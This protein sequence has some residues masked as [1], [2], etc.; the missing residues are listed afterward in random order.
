MAKDLLTL[1]STVCKEIGLPVPA[2]AASSNE[3][4]TMQLV[5]YANACGLELMEA[6]E[7]PWLRKLATIN[8]VATQSVYS[9]A[10]SA[11]PLAAGTYT[12]NRL[13]KDTEFD[14]TNHWRFLGSI[15]DSEWNSWVYGVQ[16]TPI[17][18]IFRT[19]AEDQIEVWPV[20][21]ASSG[22][23][24]LNFIAN[25]WV[26]GSGSP[27]PVQ[28]AFVADT[29]VHLFDQRLFEVGV[30]W[31]WKAG[32]GLEFAEDRD[33]YDKRLDLRKAH[34]RTARR[35]SLTGGRHAPHFLDYQNVPETGYGS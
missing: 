19:V 21:S 35:L 24:V 27:R 14:A 33:Q 34:S 31:R 15:S 26:Q 7:W 16:T 25:E 11:A 3:K 1:V 5:A 18:K 10:A 12:A 17:R 28:S 23:L 30:K 8:L 9:I 4:Q 32:N 6:S 20:P 29:D 13:V 2:V 22:Q